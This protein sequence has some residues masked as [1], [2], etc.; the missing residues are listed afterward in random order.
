[1]Q[2]AFLLIRRLPNGM[3]NVPATMLREVGI[4]DETAAKLIR[5]AK[6]DVLRIQ[7][8][9]LLRDCDKTQLPDM[10]ITVQQKEAW[11]RYRSALRDMPENLTDLDNVQWPV[12]PGIL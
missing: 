11:A 10:P 4:D 12:P 9:Q 6:L 3:Q 2:H 8:D 5:E 7:R 1:M